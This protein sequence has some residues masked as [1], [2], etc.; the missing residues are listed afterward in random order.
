MREIDFDFDGETVIVTG[1]SSGIG[2]EI[3]L[4]FGRGGA[5]VIVADITKESLDPD[6]DRPTHEVIIDGGGEATFVETD[7]ADPGAIDSVVAEARTHGGVSVMV[8]NAGIIDRSSLLEATPEDF[9]RLWAVNVNGILFG[10]QRAAR[11]MI[12]R[13]EPGVIVNTASISSDLA[14]YDH[15]LYDA[16][17][18]AVKMITRAAAMDL[19][20]AGIRVNA[21]APGFIATNISEDGRA[22]LRDAVANEEVIKPVP[23]G[24]AGSPADIAPAVA[25]LASDAAGYITGELLHVDGGYQVV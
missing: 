25:Y 15:V 4:E 11:D 23:L 16:T 24:R 10:C 8:N 5:A 13:D 2:R 6:A 9:E 3:A 21:V 19:S 12:D 14:M 17:K 22:A 1:G 7:V 18:G 20:D